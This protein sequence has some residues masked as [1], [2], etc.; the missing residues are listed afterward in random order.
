MANTHVHSHAAGGE[1]GTLNARHHKLALY[2]FLFV[3]LAH[4]AEHLAQAFQIYAMGWAVPKAKG[5]LGLWFPWLIT[6]EVLHYAFALVMLVSLFALR[7]G[8]VGRARTW[9]SIALVLQFWHHVEHLLLIMQ[10]S[11][12][13]NLLGRPVPTSIV[14]L[15]VP[16][17][18]LHL[19]YNFIVFVPMVVAM[20]LHMRPNREER[21]QMRC[22]CAVP[23]MA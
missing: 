16:R 12:G 8:F 15:L 20:V 6:S 2:A 19:F 23:A 14:Q 1:T 13:V 9:W 5:V 17:V 3:V 22:T 21:A 11:T 18:E 10:S 4:W 7:K